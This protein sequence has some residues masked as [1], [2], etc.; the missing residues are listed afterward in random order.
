M[1]NVTAAIG[2]GQSEMAN[3]HVAERRRIALRYLEKLAPLQESGMLRLPVEPVDAHNV[4]WLFSVVLTGGG[5]GRRERIRQTLLAAHGIET[6]PFFV[7]MHKLPMFRTKRHFPHSEFLGEHGINLPTYSGLSANDIDEICA[8]LSDI[9][10]RES[11]A[12]VAVE[13]AGESRPSVVEQAVRPIAASHGRT[14]SVA[15]AVSPE[16]RNG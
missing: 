7:P 14:D 10:A 1:T 8:A 2:L 16:T 15:G 6:R 9:I 11:G 4:Y 5:E 3:S 13:K 12:T